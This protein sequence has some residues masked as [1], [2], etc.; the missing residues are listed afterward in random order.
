MQLFLP[1]KVIIASLLAVAA[2][3]TAAAAGSP[4]G[5]GQPS[6]VAAPFAVQTCDSREPC[7]AY[8]NHNQGPGVQSFSKGSGIVGVSEATRAEASPHAGVLGR[9]NSG[10]YNAAGVWGIAKYGRGVVGIVEQDGDGSGIG[11]YGQTGTGNGVVGSTYEG[12]GVEGNA[13]GIGIGVVG[14]TSDSDGSAIVGIS[15]VGNAIFAHSPGFTALDATGGGKAPNGFPLPTLLIQLQGPGPTDLIQAYG[16]AGN[17]MSLDDTGNIRITGLLYTAGGCST[18]CDVG[19][20]T[21]R[22]VESY[23]PSQSQRSMEDFGKGQL[24]DG[25]AYVRLDPAFANVIERQSEYLVF[26][27]P[28]GDSRGLYVADKTPSGFS[29][30]ENQGGRSTLAFDYRIVAKPYADT[31]KRLPMIQMPA[32]PPVRDDRRFAKAHRLE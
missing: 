16:S 30:R 17:T 2:A 15:D 25:R 11:V 14:E 19:G 12:Y 31:T 8:R 3:A 4:D 27:T 10:G 26:I 28:E 29:V 9:D 23:A 24:V 5:K 32:K 20:K 13:L 7:I 21:V 22:R 6:G 1:T 18:G